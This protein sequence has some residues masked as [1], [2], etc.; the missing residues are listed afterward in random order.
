MLNKYSANQTEA[1]EIL[2]YVI[3]NGF[4]EKLTEYCTTKQINGLKT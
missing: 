1:I 4:V 2:L 3:T